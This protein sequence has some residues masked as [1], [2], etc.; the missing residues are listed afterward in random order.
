[1]ALLWR[2]GGRLCRHSLSNGLVTTESRS[3]AITPSI[4]G[5]ILRQQTI[6]PR[7]PQ[8]W[9]SQTSIRAYRHLAQ[10]PEA[11]DAKSN[12]TPSTTPEITAARAKEDAIRQKR[13]ESGDDP[14]K[15]AAAGNTTAKQQRET[16]WSIV[17]RLIG[18]VWPKGETGAKTRVI[19]ALALLV[20]GK[21]SH[22]WLP[23]G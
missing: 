23:R 14:L 22:R 1:M 19:L 3:L 8:V 20:G 21:V 15:L 17:R 16:D 12:V 6:P 10:P 5:S 7:Q 2:S 9:L 18:H 11:P 13:Q 4:T